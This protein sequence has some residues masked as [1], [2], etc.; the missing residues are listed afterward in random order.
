MPRA[1]TIVD[2]LA[3]PRLFG[4]VS[5]FRDLS[6]WRRWIIFLKS[7]YGLALDDEE[8]A[9][10]TEHT[11]RSQYDPPVGVWSETV[12]VVG[13]QS[14]KSRVASVIAGFE[15]LRAERE[16][17]GTETWALLIA[18]DQRAALRTLLGYAKAPFAQV[19]ALQRSVAAT[20]ADSLTLENNV[21]LAAY[22]SR[23]QAVRGLRARIAVLDELAF[24][25][26]SEGFPIDKEMLR[27][28]R[29]CLATTGGKL[30][31]LSSPYAQTGALY[32]LHRRHFGRDDSD[33]LVWA[34]SAPAMNPSLP[35]DYLERMARDDPEAYR[36]EVLGEFRTGVATF[37]DPD[38]VAACV[39]SGVRER[40]PQPSAHYRAFFDPSGGRRDRAALAIAHSARQET[41]AVL[42]VMRAWSPPFNPAGVIAEAAD[43]LRDYRLSQVQGDRYAG[44]FV[45]EAFRTHRITYTPSAKDKSSIYLELLPLVQ[46]ERI[47]LL[48]QSELLRELRGLERRRGGAGRDRVDH[49]GAAHD[50]R[51]NSAAGALVAASRP[52]TPRWLIKR[53]LEAGR[54]NPE[55]YRPRF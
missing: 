50:D 22:P 12:A 48:D 16:G 26:N 41:V 10:F 32:D 52:Q 25:R 28:I 31:I 7:V 39:D 14:G 19:P 24:F 53:C 18:Q 17:D 35:T 45:A 4:G 44:E 27:A 23:P 40:P 1:L 3:D 29:P 54:G 34:G 38:A 15:A 11:G 6:S 36:S 47:R 49:P 55:D 37:L 20:R 13:R 5:A 21:V 8:A 43:V 51:A 42:D 33:T 9:I 46:S 2:A 30:L